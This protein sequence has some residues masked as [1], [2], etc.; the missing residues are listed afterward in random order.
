MKVGDKI[1]YTP[2]M[3]AGEDKPSEGTI[4]MIEPAGHMFRMDM[5][6][7]DTVEHWIPAHECRPV[8]AGKEGA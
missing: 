2:V 5:L 8:E 6:V 4:T 1:R 3:L 7:I